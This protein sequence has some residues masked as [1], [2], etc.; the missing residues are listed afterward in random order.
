VLQPQIIISA[1]AHVDLLGLE[2]HIA[3]QDGQTRADLIL[4]RIEETIRMLAFMPGL[5]RSRRYLGRSTRVFPQPP[6]LIIYTTLPDLDGIRVIRVI[7]GRR[8][9]PAVLG[10]RR[11]R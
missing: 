8:D 11:R 10:R 5:G 6:W 3:D 9:L 4:G 2:L 7:D 1:E